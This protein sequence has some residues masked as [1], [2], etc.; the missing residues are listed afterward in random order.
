MTRNR[1]SITNR[2]SREKLDY[3]KEVFKRN[4]ECYH[5]SD[6]LAIDMCMDITIKKHRWFKDGGFCLNN[7]L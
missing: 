5:I 2:K 3:I 7:K 1:I 6:S 4:I